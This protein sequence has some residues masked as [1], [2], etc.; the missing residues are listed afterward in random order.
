MSLAITTSIPHQINILLIGQLYV[1]TILHVHDF[2][3]ED[4]KTRANY[5]EQR[6]GGNTCNTAKVLSQYKQLNVCYMSAAGSHD[7][8]RY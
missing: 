1:D 2:P 7:N 6:T 4:S 3:E 8:S 5:A